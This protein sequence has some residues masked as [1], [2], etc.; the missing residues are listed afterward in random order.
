M[1]SIKRRAILYNI[2]IPQQ[3]ILE[4]VPKLSLEGA[5]ILDYISR[6]ELFSR[7]KSRKATIKNEEYVWL[8]YSTLIANLPILKIRSKDRVT[9][10][11]NEL[12]K[13]G[14][15]KKEQLKDNTLFVKLTDLGAS[16]YLDLPG[17]SLQSGQLSSL[18][19]T[20]PVP[21]VGTAQYYN[22]FIL[23]TV[24]DETHSL[25]SEIP[26][27]KKPDPTSEIPDQK[28]PDPTSEIPDQKKPDP[29]VKRVIDFFFEACKELKGF[30]PRISGAIEGKMIKDYLKEYSE[31][32]LIEELDWFLRSKESETLGCTIKIAL[33]NYVFNKWLS[34][35]ETL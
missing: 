4:V 25:S 5:V 17:L 19:G 11:I 18:K 30:P 2:Q 33:C 16:L 9:R 14:L 8:H 23:D 10:R 13:L 21:T 24:S 29:R 3:R 1:K 12:V 34:S 27:R 7:D 15:L 26:D 28:K 6:W 35:R 32:E 31:E 22:Y 20:G